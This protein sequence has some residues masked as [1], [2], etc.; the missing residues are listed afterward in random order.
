MTQKPKRKLDGGLSDSEDFFY[1]ILLLLNFV[2][3]SILHEASEHCDVQI[4][5]S[6]NFV[7]IFAAIFELIDCIS[8]RKYGLENQ[9]IH[10]LPR[11]CLEMHLF[12][13]V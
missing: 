4:L 13:R 12:H 1:F 11:V 8:S 3:L 6:R 9:L 2:V 5:S 10:P 7:I